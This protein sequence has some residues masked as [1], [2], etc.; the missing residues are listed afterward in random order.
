MTLRPLMTTFPRKGPQVRVSPLTSIEEDRTPV[1]V[2]TVSAIDVAVDVIPTNEDA[3]ANLVAVGALDIANAEVF[4]GNGELRFGIRQKALTGLRARVHCAFQPVGA[5]ADSRV[6]SLLASV[7]E[8]IEVRI[9]EDTSGDL[10]MP[11]LPIR[12]FTQGV[13]FLDGHQPFCG[14]DDFK[15]TFAIPAG[16]LPEVRLFAAALVSAEIYL[17][18][19]FQ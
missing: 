2:D 10:V 3:I 6:A 4:V 19:V 17:E 13:M 16:G 9:S 18:A 11:A 8:R 7:L 14:S 12:A 5:A 15:I 1:Y